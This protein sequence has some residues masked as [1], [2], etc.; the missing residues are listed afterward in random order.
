MMSEHDIRKINTGWQTIQQLIRLQPAGLETCMSR[1]F[2]L[3]RR[4]DNTRQQGGQEF[5]QDLKLGV[6]SSVT[7]GVISSSLCRSMPFHS[8]AVKDH[9]MD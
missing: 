6:I 9:D 2:L 5:S 8:E 4:K 3:E 7:L 1:D